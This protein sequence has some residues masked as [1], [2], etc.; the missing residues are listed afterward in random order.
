[1]LQPYTPFVAEELWHLVADRADGDDIIIAEWPKVGVIDETVLSEFKKAT[2]VITQIRNI[3]KQNNIANKVRLEMH[4]K[5]NGEVNKGMDSVVSKMG[6]LSV[7]E[8][9]TEKVANANSFLVDSNEYFIP[10]GDAI[11]VD[12]EKEKINEELKYTKGF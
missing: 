12:A 5:L 7:L 9:T 4:V 8:Y 11:D 6:N 10:F 3:R 1:M 2:E